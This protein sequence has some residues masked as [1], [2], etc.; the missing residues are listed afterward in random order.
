MTTDDPDFLMLAEAAG[1][2]ISSFADE[3][4]KSE[5]WVARVLGRKTNCTPSEARRIAEIL[6][7]D[8]VHTLSLTVRQTR[9]RS[10]VVVVGVQ[11]LDRVVIGALALF[12]ALVVEHTFGS[13]TLKRERALAVSNVNS[14]F[15]LERY[16]QAKTDFVA[17]LVQ[18][19]SVRQANDEEVNTPEAYAAASN[20][21]TLRNRLAVDIDFMATAHPH[22]KNSAATFTAALLDATDELVER[23]M[24]A[25][26]GGKVNL[27]RKR[28][29]EFS[30]ACQE[31]M[32]RTVE[33]ELREIEDGRFLW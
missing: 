28:F 17:L 12:V 23:R 21:Q 30:N 8:P 5:F 22:T 7:T 24:P 1:K 25:D 26:Y 31:A 20:I 9:P 13:F 4:Q 6:G 32:V 19:E 3:L 33:T 16:T 14:Q 15:L 11:V 2:S 10:P 18:I 29:F 27:L